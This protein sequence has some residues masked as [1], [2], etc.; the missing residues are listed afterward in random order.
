MAHAI[1]MGHLEETILR[2]DGTDFDRL[3]KNVVAR[4]AGHGGRF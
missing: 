3:E 4:V 2:G 1:A